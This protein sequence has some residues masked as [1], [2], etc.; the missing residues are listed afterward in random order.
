MLSSWVLLLVTS[1]TTESFVLSRRRECR[2]VV[3]RWGKKKGGQGQADLKR[4]LEEARAAKLR[5]LVPLDSGEDEMVGGG[6]DDVV[7]ANQGWRSRAGAVK[8]SKVPSGS[9]REFEQQMET[10]KYAAAYERSDEGVMRIQQEQQQQHTSIKPR[11]LSRGEA[12]PLDSWSEL[13]DVDGRQQSFSS[14]VEEG[15]LVCCITHFRR[16]STS[17]KSAVEAINAG[18]PR[19][20]PVKLVAVTGDGPS[21]NRRLQ[22]KC[23]VPLTVLS[24]GD[25]ERS[26]W[27]PAHGLTSA[28]SRLE[29]AVFF[30]LPSGY[31]F[32]VNY[33]SAP[34]N[35]VPYI[36]DA[37]RAFDIT[38]KQT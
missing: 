26:R 34:Q 13:V 11:V 27:F 35:L 36:K 14:F 18:L 5:P 21:T 17:L 7:L 15:S 20:L 24:A 22:K 10:S 19:T 8:E 12:A 31:L 28:F 33:N 6:E 29:L 25:P 3:R 23:K 2:L 32:S 37:C 16:E 9:Y 38:N 30:I 1:T 4:K